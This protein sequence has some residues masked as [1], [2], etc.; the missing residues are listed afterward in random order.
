V[1]S[2]RGG[3]HRLSTL[4][5]NVLRLCSR[6]NTQKRL[7][8]DW[9]QTA[10]QAYEAGAFLRLSTIIT[11][12][13]A[14]NYQA[15][16]VITVIFHLTSTAGKAPDTLPWRWRLGVRLMHSRQLRTLA[17]ALAV[18]GVSVLG[19]PR[20]TNADILV[21]ITDG[22]GASATSE[23]LYSASN[24]GAA[25]FSETIGHYDISLQTVVTSYP[26]TLAGGSISTNVNILSTTGTGTLETLTV[27][28]QLVNHNSSSPGSSTNLLWSG[29]TGSP[30]Y[31]SAGERE[32]RNRHHQH[33]LQQ[34][35]GQDN[36]RSWCEHRLGVEQR[37]GGINLWF[38]L[39]ADTQCS[40]LLHP[41][42]DTDTVGSQ[43]GSI[44]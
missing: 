30:L 28:V 33:V 24:A 8:C 41:G 16:T 4:R 40:R 1:E 17:M 31:V 3:I 39:C 25:F 21:T 19:H 36:D 23:T 6:D 18:I 35:D 32:I 29:P 14:R 26:G 13:R 2:C 43:R 27:Q 9:P 37:G 15:G 22:S 10:H 42:T 34:Y 12:L 11:R 38:Q 20:T 7:P 5:L 44:R